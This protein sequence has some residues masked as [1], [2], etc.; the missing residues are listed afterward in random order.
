MLKRNFTALNLLFSPFLQSK[1]HSKKVA[2]IG[3]FTAFLIVVNSFISFPIGD[4]QFSLTMLVSMLS[5][6]ILGPFAGFLSCFVADLIGYFINS[7]GL[8]YYFWVGIS[9]SLFAFIA[10]LVFNFN[11]H[12]NNTLM[13]IV[14]ALITILITF[15][16][17]TVFINSTGFYIYNTNIGALT[18]AIEYAKQ[19][20]GTEISFLIYLAYR[21]IFKGQIFNSLFNYAL[22][23]AVIPVLKRLKLL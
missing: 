14:K 22:F 5:G 12:K 19:T 2:Y 3:L 1:S 20:F 10:G 23:F 7:G 9:T 13:L 8:F 21:L 4:V 6:I 11:R 15:V 17:C 18:K 16:I